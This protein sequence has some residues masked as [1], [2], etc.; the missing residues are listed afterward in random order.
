MKI[1]KMTASEITIGYSTLGRL[2][3]WGFLFF[4]LLLALVEI[5]NL[6]GGE[7]GIPLFVVLFAALAMW[8]PWVMA[9][10]IT[11]VQSQDIFNVKRHSLFF[12]TTKV[13]SMDQAQY[14]FVHSYQQFYSSLHLGLSTDTEYE[15]LVPAV[16]RYPT[17]AKFGDNN[18]SAESLVKWMQRAIAQSPGRREGGS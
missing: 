3:G 14:A 18:S 1:T 5:S 2:V 15:V 16:G 8:F 7:W 12:S 4:A 11:F 9:V 10:K 6:T 13:I 17:I